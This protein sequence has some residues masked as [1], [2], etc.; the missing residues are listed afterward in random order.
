MKKLCVWLDD[1]LVGSLGPHGARG[2]SFVYEADATPADA[3]SLTLP[4]RQASY[5]VSSGLLPVFDTNLPEGALLEKI[6]RAIAKNDD[7]RVSPIDVLAMT[8]GNQIGRIRVLPPDQQ[9]ERR[10]P[11]AEIGDILTSD[12]NSSLVNDI[13]ERYS[14]RSGVSGQMPKALVETRAG[15]DSPSP[16]YPDTSRAESHG[17]SSGERI[18]V[19]TRDW[20]LKFDAT[21]YPGLSLNEYHCLQAARRA[22]NTVADARLSNDGCMLAVKRFDIQDGARIAFEDFACL[23]AKTSEAK[24]QGSIETALLK[25]TWA[26]SAQDARENLERLYR[27][28]LTRI[29]LRD[30]DAHLK[31]Y[32]LLYKD[33]VAGPF[34]IAP[35][36]DIVTTRAFEELRNDNM[37][38][39]LNGKKTWPDRKSLEKL[40]ARAYLKPAAAKQIMED[41]RSGIVAQM[42]HL[43]MDM[44]AHDQM[45]LARAILHEW[46]EGIE[47]SLGL[48]PIDIEAVIDKAYATC[49]AIEEDP[50][51]TLAGQEE[52]IMTM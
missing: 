1:K 38:L 32:G 21:D 10:E 34:E 5:D 22:G 49:E 2:S 43:V 50:D 19:Q 41:I 40:A 39:T 37:S 31:N 44:I 13:I 25:Q 46:N 48:E 20:I 12:S 17:L 36:F 8:G 14:L 7:G 35:A 24:Y 29:A 3:I 42:P 6:R 11:I 30:G 52:D 45:D 23:N 26:F 4:V 33:P 15:E 28:I 9:P 47:Q 27:Q 18:T 51:L 16:T